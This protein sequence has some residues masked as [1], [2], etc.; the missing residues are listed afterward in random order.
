MSN[1]IEIS[2]RV[3]QL[4]TP[5]VCNSSPEGC[6]PDENIIHDLT[7]HVYDSLWDSGATA[8][9]LV[10]CCWHCMKE[11]SLLLGDIVE[12][13]PLIMKESDTA[14]LITVEQ[15]RLKSIGIFVYALFHRVWILESYLLII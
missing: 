4:V 5:V 10:I 6:L 2:T 11:V 15:V 7:S 8:Q 12:R 14:G 3:A 13:A 9:S 1:L